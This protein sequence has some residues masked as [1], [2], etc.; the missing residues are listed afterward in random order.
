MERLYARY[1]PH[2][3]MS[4]EPIKHT[5]KKGQRVESPHKFGTNLGNHNHDRVHIAADGMAYNLR[6]GGAGV[7]KHEA[8]NNRQHDPI[9]Q[10][11]EI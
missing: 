11:T 1:I 4:G 8:H 5:T 3:D 10:K 9:S 6:S 7:S 2:D